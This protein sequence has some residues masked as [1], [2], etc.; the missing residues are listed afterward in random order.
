VLVVVCCVL[1]MAC[2][3]AASQQWLLV[4]NRWYETL[5]LLLVCFTLFRPAY[6]LDQF[7]KPF[8]TRPASEI[9]SIAEGAPLGS[10]IRIRV[11]SQTRLGEDVD[12]V[13]RLTMRTEG[14]GADR[15]KRQGLTLSTLG[16]KV[17]V[18]SVGFGSEAAKYG[19]S[20]G[21]EVLGLLVPSKRADPFWFTI[22]AFLLLG[23]ILLLQWRRKPGSGATP[24][25]A[26]A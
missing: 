3:V 23:L 20:Q 13:I 12:K 7:Q 21:D 25:P 11:A 16:G 9:A 8:E 17:T 5:L 22:P 2:F 10:T 6:W 14:S 26:A 18:Q 15:L 1:A 4:R 24:M 19:L